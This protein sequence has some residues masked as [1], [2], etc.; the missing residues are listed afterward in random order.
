MFHDF[1]FG[2]VSMIMMNVKSVPDSVRLDLGEQ[3]SHFPHQ[4]RR[5]FMWQ[6]HQLY[7]T[8]RC[9]SSIKERLSADPYFLFMQQQGC[10]VH[11]ICL[12][13]DR[14]RNQYQYVLYL[15]IT[16]AAREITA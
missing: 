13:Y 11:T 6:I 5:E 10:E 15:D 3:L 2:R 8:T 12:Q 14:P 7:Q 9:V 4:Q 1:D 16:G